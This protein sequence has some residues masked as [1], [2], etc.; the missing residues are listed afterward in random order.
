MSLLLSPRV[1][2]ARLRTAYAANPARFR[3]AFVAVL[4]VVVVGMSLK[5][6]ANVSLSRGSRIT[7]TAARPPAHSPIDTQYAGT[8]WT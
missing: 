2:L 8:S 7:P 4:A 3:A 5:Y 6:A 1:L